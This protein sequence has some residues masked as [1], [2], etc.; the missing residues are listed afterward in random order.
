MMYIYICL[1]EHVVVGHG[2]AHQE[3]LGGRRVHKVRGYPTKHDP[4]MILKS[5]YRKKKLM[6]GH[7]IWTS[8]KYCASY[9]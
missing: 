4:E 2:S 6:G 8:K 1:N 9:S 7:H 3:G 5:I